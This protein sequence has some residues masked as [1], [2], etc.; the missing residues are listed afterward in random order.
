MATLQS[1]AKELR[2]DLPAESYRAVPSRLLWL[3]VH[4]AIIGV[5]YTAILADE[6][7][8]GVKLLLSIAIGHSFTCLAFL[9]HEI[10]HGTVVRQ[11]FLQDIFG[12]LCFLPHCLPPNVWRTWHNRF[13]HGYVGIKGKDPDG[14]GDPVMYRR[15]RLLHAILSFLPGSGR[16]RSAFYFLFYFSFHVLFVLFLHS[17]KYKY[18]SARKW[19]NQVGLFT[20]EIVFWAAV[21]SLVGFS[22]FIFVY[23]VP[24]MVANTIQMTYV[25]TNHWLCDE[26][27]DENDPLRNSLSVK[28]PRIVDWLHLNASYH[29]EHHLGPTINPRH[30]PLIH[31]AMAARHGRRCRRLSLF[32]I[33]LMTYRTPRVHLSENELVN[34]QNGN[35]YTTLGPRGEPPMWIE[36]VPVPIRRRRTSDPNNTLPF[37][38]TGSLSSVCRRTD[39]DVDESDSIISFPGISSQRVP[40][41]VPVPIPRPT[42]A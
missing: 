20:L 23:L 32:Q 42:A 21:G 18:W 19:R 28:L 16:L 24:M 12:G 5:A 14:F 36:Q 4:L 7:T 30:A 9:A 8:L 2:Q 33:L 15:S 29:T 31:K 27:H 10:L 3:P 34:I 35:V 1:Y 41:F 38:E 37:P 22:N 25:T 40:A 13:H 11:R 6:R 39:A 17:R 26:T